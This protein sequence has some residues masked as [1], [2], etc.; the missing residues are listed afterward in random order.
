MLYLGIM[1]FFIQVLIQESLQEPKIFNY[2]ILQGNL[3]EMSNRQDV[4]V[5]RDYSNT[6]KY[7]NQCRKFVHL[8]IQYAMCFLQ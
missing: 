4:N 7:K 6:I 8:I 3:N 5:Q 2:N 1:I